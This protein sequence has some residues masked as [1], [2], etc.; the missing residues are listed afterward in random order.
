MLQRDAQ[1]KANE[2]LLTEL[3][4]KCTSMEAS[5]DKM[6]CDLLKER[7]THATRMH[8]HGW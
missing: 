8:Y 4:N 1:Q 3:T 2:V 6:T 7:Q 5:N